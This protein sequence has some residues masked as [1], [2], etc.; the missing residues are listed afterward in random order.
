MTDLDPEVEADMAA[1]PENYG[2]PLMRMNA[3]SK[4]PIDLDMTEEKWK[5]IAMALWILLDD[6]D[7]LSDACKPEKNSFY[8]YTMVAVEKRFR[9]MGSDGQR[10]WP[11]K[12]G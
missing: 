12:I 10:L 7:T 6:I 3:G 8:N 11:V 5:A 2:R 4:A 9:M 1:N